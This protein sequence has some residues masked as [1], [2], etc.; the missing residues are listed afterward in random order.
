[1]PND[2][3][4]ICEFNPIQPLSMSSFHSN[5]IKHFKLNHAIVEREEV[6]ILFVLD[7]R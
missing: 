4:H 6:L 1:M 5:S 7:S 2:I 3:A